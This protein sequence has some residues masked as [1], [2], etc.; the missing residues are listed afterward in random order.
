MSP[1][2][3]SKS[4]RVERL[5]SRE[6][7]A[8]Y[9]GHWQPSD[10]DSMDVPMERDAGK[11][12]GEWSKSARF[13]GS[14]DD[15]RYEASEHFMD[16][17]GFA[18]GEMDPSGIRAS[19][20]PMILGYAISAGQINI[21]L[22]LFIPASV[23]T[24]P[25][26]ERTNV[27]TLEFPWNHDIDVSGGSEDAFAEGEG[28]EEVTNFTRVQ[29]SP[30]AHS[31]RGPER[32]A[33]SRSPLV[34]VGDSIRDSNNKFVVENTSSNE[35][36][37]I[38]KARFN[39][40]VTLDRFQIKD[41]YFAQ[42]GGARVD[43]DDVRTLQ[44]AYLEL[45]TRGFDE[46]VASEFFRKLESRSIDEIQLNWDYLE[47]STIAGEWE[48]A[49]FSENKQQS[50]F[51]IYDASQHGLGDVAPN[52]AGVTQLLKAAT[53]RVDD[54]KEVESSLTDAR[55]WVISLAIASVWF[56][57][58]QQKVRSRLVGNMSLLSRLPKYFR[59]Q[60]DNR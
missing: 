45:F 59:K 54:I 10:W 34:A 11:D 4:L 40:E 47:P 28:G 17:D 57:F 8:S 51:D 36:Y 49:E 35:S 44:D 15:R 42:L 16:R 23:K 18:K 37:F 56:G 46:E 6:L 43:N 1:N 60:R 38:S 31:L 25:S 39:T 26:T 12:V 2:W 58:Q 50:L 13:G 19:T 41:D 21:F 53:E 33:T 22:G 27:P 7:M 24:N 9:L 30:A 32:Q 14:H 5:E 52:S 55:Y 48:R 29:E 3:K 20:G